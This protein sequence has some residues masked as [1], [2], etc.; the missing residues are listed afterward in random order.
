MKRIVYVMLALW[1]A[2]CMQVAACTSM[3]V[4]GKYTVSG[5]PVMLKHRDTD[6]LQNDIRRYQGERYAFI[7]LCN[8]CG[9]TS[10]KAIAEAWTGTNEAGFSIM[11]TAS[12]NIKND[13]I[14]D[15]EMDMEG[16]LMYEALGVCRTVD[17]FETFLR[18]HAKPLGVEANFGVID[19]EGGAAYFETNNYE[20]V[21]Y[22]VDDEPNGLRVVTNFCFAGRYEDR[23]GWERYLTAKDIV[24]SPLLEQQN[25]KWN[26]DHTWCINHISRSYAHHILGTREDYCPENGVAV[27]QDF[28]P[29]RI[30]SAVLVIEGVCPGEDPLHTVMWTALGYPATSMMVPLMVGRENIL[31][32]CVQSAGGKVAPLCAASDEVKKKYVFTFGISNGR[33]Y[34]NLGAIQRDDFYYG[35]PALRRCAM[36]AEAQVNE[37]FSSL[38]QKWVNG[39]V[40]DE[41]FYQLYREQGR[42]WPEIYNQA[43][44]DYK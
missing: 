19:A 39:Q 38:Y 15:S 22:N 23:M 6:C 9:N 17:E 7:A 18:E 24:A 36:Q 10:S 4:S 34:F 14:P 41:Q 25:G 2:G 35:K 21:R 11:N 44:T 33:H 37:R 30:T 16:A 20:W 43:F 12:Y 28:I 42:E 26:I 27:D 1:V 5:K 40:S 29:R 13:T 32:A 3:I 31:P 8:T